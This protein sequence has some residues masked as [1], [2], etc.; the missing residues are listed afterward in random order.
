MIFFH[1]TDAHTAFNLGCAN[2]QLLIIGEKRIHQLMGVPDW[3]GDRLMCVCE[4][5]NGEDLPDGLTLGDDYRLFCEEMLAD[6]EE[7]SDRELETF[8]TSITEWAARDFHSP[9]QYKWNGPHGLNRDL[10]CDR[11]SEEV[12]IAL[13]LANPATL[14]DSFDVLWNLSKRVYVLRR[15][16]SQ[17]LYEDVEAFS[18]ESVL[19]TVLVFMTCWSTRPG[20]LTWCCEIH[21]RGYNKGEWAGDRFEITSED[22]LE[23]RTKEEGSIWKD[24]SKD[25][26]HL[27]TG[28]FE[29]VD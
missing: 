9:V 3:K 14:T 21:E 28:I 5:S 8:G 1:T 2:T 13:D 20:G 15:T 11:L 29:C 19:G 10:R 26:I 6:A 18:Y 16:I 7:S 27:W 12:G 24:A 22:I 25:I 4:S 23:S 17:K